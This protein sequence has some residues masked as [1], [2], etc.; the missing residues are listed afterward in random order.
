MHQKMSGT[1][2][3]TSLCTHDEVYLDAD[4]NQH[5]I[6]CNQCGRWWRCYGDVQDVWRDFL[7][8]WMPDGHP[9]ATVKVKCSP[10]PW[11]P[12]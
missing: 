12:R 10:T 3:A 7:R 8:Y 4:T 5:L 1:S 11:V 2:V 9:P 6:E